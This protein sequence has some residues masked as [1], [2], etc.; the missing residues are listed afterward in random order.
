MTRSGRARP[1]GT[2]QVRWSL[3]DQRGVRF[4]GDKHIARA[5]LTLTTEGVGA[6]SK[7]TSNIFQLRVPFTENSTWT[8]LSSGIQ[9][10]TDT[11]SSPIATTGKLI[12]RARARV[13]SM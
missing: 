5:I 8:S 13:R 10:G 12:E 11:E 2:D 9:I 6:T 1:R 4:R 3:W 7:T